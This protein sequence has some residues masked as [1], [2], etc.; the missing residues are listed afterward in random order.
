MSATNSPLCDLYA[1]DMW[2]QNYTGVDNPGPEIVK[3]ELKKVNHK[4]KIYFHDGNSRITIPKFK[5][6][7]PKIFFDLIC[8]DGDHSLI[9]ASKDL[10]NVIDML[11]IGGFLI[12]DDTNSFEHPF[13]KSVWHKIV[14][15]RDNL[16]SSEF[17]EHGLGVSI[18]T[19]L[20]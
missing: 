18:A 1:F 7:N 20:F 13:L 6:E 9:G 11:K 19:R 16:I 5:K 12:F 10:K 3:N 14:K 4:G 2:I 15:K 17:N 8:V